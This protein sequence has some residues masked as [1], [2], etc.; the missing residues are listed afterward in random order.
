MG[1]AARFTVSDL[2]RAVKGFEKAGVRVSG[3]R[4]N[5]DGSIVVLT[6]GSEVA[7]DT[8]NPLDRIL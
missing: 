4:I 7:N 2:T 8:G 3:A 5:P 1:R 6:S